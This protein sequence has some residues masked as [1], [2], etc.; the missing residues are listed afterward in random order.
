MKNRDSNISEEWLMEK[1]SQIIADPTSVSADELDTLMGDDS[2]RIAYR[3][4]LIVQVAL[5]DAPET[6]DFMETV[7]KS[8]SSKHVSR[9]WGRT[10]TMWVMAA[11]VACLAAFLVLNKEDEVNLSIPKGAEL[12]YKA[13]QESADI[14]IE[15]KGEILDISEAQRQKV[16]SVN[17][18]EISVAPVGIADM[19]SITVITVPQG[20]VACLR[21][22]DGTKVWLNAD[23]RILYPE[24]FNPNCERRVKI[25]GEVSFDVVHD[26][27]RP[28][29]VEFAKAE[30][31]VL[32]TRFN[33]RAYSN[34]VP[35]VTLV[36]GSVRL[37]ASGKQTVMRPGKQVKIGDDGELTSYSVD[38]WETTAW[39]DGHL[40]MNRKSFR[41]VMIEVGRQY[42]KNVI[43]LSDTHK[44]D[45]IHFC[46][47]R[48]WNLN[49]VVSVLGD[50]TDTRIAVKGN[51][52][53]VE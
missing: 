46:I 33:V 9:Q 38:T 1:V 40:Y 2:F 14:T 52:I 16:V 24:R 12:V 32:G 51:N 37:Q 22:D 4:A 5:H 28:F 34:E 19:Y 7:G 53:E 29:I 15:S 21:L 6:P 44:R 11:A 43:F 30:L 18:S 49:D 20:K 31:T 50:I 10:V 42:N 47:E 48:S 36:S 3:E 26:S 27:K 45:T 23:S 8:G 39:I 41:D 13:A 17:D 25:E 35:Q